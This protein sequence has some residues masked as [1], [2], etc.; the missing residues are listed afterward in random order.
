[1][2][3]ELSFRRFFEL[4]QRRWRFFALIGALAALLSGALSGPTFIRP[5]FRSSAIVYPVNLTSYSIE[6]R[7]D[8][9]LQLLERNSIR[10][11]LLRKFDLATHWRLDTARAAGRH[12]LYNEFLDRVEISKTRYESVQVEVLDEDPLMARDIVQEMLHQADLLARRLQREK[13]AEVLAI[14]E[15]AM[16][17]ERRKIDSAETRL[18]ELRE[19]GGLLVYEAQTEELVKGYVRM[20]SQ[21]ASSAQKDE[22]KRMLDQLATNGGEF[23]SLTDMTDMFRQNYNRLLTEFELAVNDVN[24]E[25]TYTNVVVY[26]EVPDKKVWPIRWLIVAISTASA[27]FLAFVLLAWRESDARNGAASTT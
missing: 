2:S 26:P 19:T 5:K 8:Q 14:A 1:M 12:Y 16:L 11:S 18:R 13:S 6:T 25:L 20:I 15:W 21:G 4:L 9:L 17:H 3:V 10:D 23:R 7:T 24:K 27:M 22:V